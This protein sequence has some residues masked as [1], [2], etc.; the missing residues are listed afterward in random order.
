MKANKIWGALLA[1]TVGLA[2]IM[3]PTN[4]DAQK[5]KKA[6]KVEAP[7]GPAQ[8]VKPIKIQPDSANLKWG[9][10][11]K[12]TEAAISKMID[13]EYKPVYQKT[14][15]GIK[16][17][18][19]DLQVAEEKNIFRRSRIDFG[20][21]PVVLDNTP[22]KGEYSYR[23]KESML[24]HRR[25]GE[26]F[27]FFFIQDRLWK[28]INELPLSEKSPN[29]KNFQDAAIKLTAQFGSVGRVIPANP[30]KQIYVTTVDWKDETTHFRL[31]ERG[32]EAAAFIYEELATLNNIDTLRANKPIV[33]DDI[34]PAVRALA[35]AKEE[36]AGPPPAA[37]KKPEKKK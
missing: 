31:V 20:T 1:T 27:Y 8:A 32:E 5:K 15:P 12:E 25:K 4:A 26:T 33:E 14:S 18:Q 29:G 19:L 28:I 17:K 3:A 6:D 35:R 2:A 37:E 30:D 24:Q 11:V 9:M 21:L 34:D 13:A 10:T 7:T 16:M 22:L 23:N 36:P